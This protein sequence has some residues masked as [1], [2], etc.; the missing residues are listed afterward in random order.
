MGIRTAG[1]L[2]AIVTATLVACGK[3]DEP[4]PPAPAAVAPAAPE[5]AA[6]TVAAPQEAAPAEFDVASVTP[7]AVALPPFPFFKDPEGLKNNRQGADALQSFDR[8][9]FLAG[10][11]YV[12]QEG[13][14]ALFEYT[15]DNP[16]SGR[17]YSPLEFQKNYENAIAALGGV[18]ISTVQFTDEVVA[19]A[20]GR[21]AIEKHWAAAS[22]PVPDAEHYTYLLRSGDKEYWIHVSSGGIIPPMGFVTVL[23]KQA[24]QSAL[25]F[26]DAAALKKELD[27]KGHVAL[28]INFDTDKA[29][30]RPDAEAPIAEVH[31]LLTNHPALKLSIEGH[32]DNTGESNHNRMLATARARTVLGALV[33]LGADPARLNSR[34]FGPDKPVADNSTETGR[35]KNRRVE[36]VKVF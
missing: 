28:Y 5:A 32:T 31:K 6:G 15:L 19:A 13:R 35:A 4:P 36:L 24:M 2:L 21:E 7:S 16:D 9:G 33:G 1:L 14:V 17:R 23:E 11:K 25:S 26:L 8:H 10:G 30:L 29:T 20:G 27:A 12:T 18:K 34:G 22:P 3:K